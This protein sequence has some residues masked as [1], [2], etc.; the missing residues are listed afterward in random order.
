MLPRMTVA[1]ESTPEPFDA[2]DD[3][4]DM[5]MAGLFSQGR[6]LF[7]KRLPIEVGLSAIVGPSERYDHTKR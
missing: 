1:P 2:S 7:A 3:A 5:Y 4:F 6:D